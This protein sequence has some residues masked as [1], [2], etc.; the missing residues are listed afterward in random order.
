MLKIS[1]VGLGLMGQQHLNA[2]NAH[3]RC[4][5][6]S[7]I[8]KTEIA[9]SLTTQKGLPYYSQLKAAIKET[10]PDGIIIATPNF[11][12]AEDAFT[13]LDYGVPILIEKPISDSLDDGVKIVN[14]AAK[15]GIPVLTGFHRRHN[16]IIHEIKD[17][18][19]S[20]LIGQIVSVHGMFWLYKPDDYFET[21]WRKKSGAGPIYINLSHD[22][23]LMRYFL[24]EIDSVQSI[25]SNKSRGFE[26]EDTSVAILNFASGVIGSISISD[27]IV[28]PWSYEF[29]SN[30]N[31]VYH[32]TS[33]NCYWIGGTDGSIE[34]P[35]GTLWVHE[36]PKGWWEPITR[37][38]KVNKKSNP[39]LNQLDNFINV[40]QGHEKPIVSGLEGLKTS[41][42]VSAIKKASN[43]GLIEKPLY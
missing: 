27:T 3:K 37:T 38:T 18:L 25:S 14:Y 35:K 12:H 16:P 39:I 19:N 8:D 34:L 31:P 33:E 42:V 6:S 9:K 22:I 20:G 40:I 15:L 2:V 17:K 10:K 1:I 24:G 41:A 4:S 30:E 29:T 28:S 21:S 13:C 43:T 23:D 32:Y 26:V 11:Q 5:V 7:V 36:G